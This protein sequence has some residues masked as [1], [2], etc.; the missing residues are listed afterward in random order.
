M[1][2]KISLKK[3]NITFNKLHLNEQ[4][5]EGTSFR[6]PSPSPFLFFFSTVVF[7]SCDVFEKVPKVTSFPLRTTY[8]HVEIRWIRTTSNG[9]FFTTLFLN[10]K[11]KKRKKTVKRFFFK[12]AFRNVLTPTQSPLSFP[13]F[14]FVSLWILNRIKFSTI[15]FHLSPSP[16]DFRI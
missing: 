5:E 15:N 10:R 7:F 12:F 9:L 3:F 6:S 14:L 8:F 16:Y 2:K 4:K 1:S 13:L 11:E